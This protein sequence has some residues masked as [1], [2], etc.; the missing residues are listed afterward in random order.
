MSW[1]QHLDH[2]LIVTA[3]GCAD[4]SSCYPPLIGCP[5]P[6]LSQLTNEP[7]FSQGMFHFDYRVGYIR[8]LPFLLC[9]LSGFLN[10]SFL[11]SCIARTEEFVLFS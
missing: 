2:D 11:D 4:V 3:Y 9:S 6:L 8:L 7:H 1:V 10:P 5:P